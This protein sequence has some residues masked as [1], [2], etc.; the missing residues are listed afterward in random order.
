MRILLGMAA[1]VC[2]VCA[3]SA[4]ALAAA[5]AN[6]TWKWSFN[7]NGNNIDILLK[8]KADGEKLSGTVA[9]GDR[10]GTEIMNGE[11]KNDEVSF[12][13]VRERN[14]QSFTTKYKGKIDGDTLKGTIQ[15]TRD[16]Q[17]RTVD[18][19]AKREK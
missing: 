4:S 5:D 10:P 14:G 11:F 2:L 12:T 1:A 16:G 6:G 7:A 3:T 19:E 18:W 15:L 9:F 8:L 17:E 13:T